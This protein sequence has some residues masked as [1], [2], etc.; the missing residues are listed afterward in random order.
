MRKFSF[1]LAIL[2]AV[3]VTGWSADANAQAADAA[4]AW[5]TMGTPGQ[6][7]VNSA[8]LHQAGGTIAQQVEAGRDG[9]PFKSVTACGT[10]TTITITGNNN[11]VFGNSITSTNFGTVSSTGIFNFDH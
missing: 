2:G 8:L 6:Q 1:G 5:G 11:S 7:F 10:C 4:V 9:G 3:L